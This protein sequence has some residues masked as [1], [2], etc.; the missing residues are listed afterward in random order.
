MIVFEE[1]TEQEMVIYLTLCQMGYKE[2]MHPEGI[3]ILDEDNESGH[4]GKQWHHESWQD[5]DQHT[6]AG[7]GLDQQEAYPHSVN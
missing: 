2:H 1:L 4:G 6:E 5:S 7:T 3:D